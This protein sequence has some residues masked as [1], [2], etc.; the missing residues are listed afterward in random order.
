MAK[1]K[2]VGVVVSNK[3]QKTIIVAVQIKY[4]HPK[5]AKTLIKTKKFMAH[6]EQNVCNLG[7]VVLLEESA[8]FSKC[9]TWVLKDILKQYLN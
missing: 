6:D 9:K 4:Q 2:R 5:Y 7:D 8:P 3:S 1:K